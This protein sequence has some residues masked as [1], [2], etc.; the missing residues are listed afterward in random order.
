MKVNTPP[1]KIYEKLR[2]IRGRPPRRINLLSMD[3]N[4]ISA[5]VDIINCLA[6]AFA[7]VSDPSNCSAEFKI[8]KER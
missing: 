3:G 5:K 2:K 4:I 8:I 1:A 6:E 7:K